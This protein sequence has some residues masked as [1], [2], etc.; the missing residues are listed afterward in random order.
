MT[1]LGRRIFV[2]CC[3]GLGALLRGAELPKGR[4]LEKVACAADATQTYALYIPT[5]ADPAHRWPVV[6]CF[7]PGARGHV[8]VERF[9]DAAEK[10]GYVIAGSNNSRNG[11]WEANA[12]AINAMVND[13]NRFLPIDAQ[14][15]YLA[16]LSGGARVACQVALGGM[17]K[18]VVACS[19]AFVGSETPERLKFAFFG[20]AG[21]TDFNYLE[22]RRTDR[23]LEERRL[24]HRVVFHSG[25]HEWLSSELAVEALAWFELQA[26]RSGAKPKDPA[27]IE[28]QFAARRAAVPEQPLA[29]RVRALRGLVADFKGL[30]AVGDVEKEAAT[31]GATREARDALKAERAAER[32]EE[33]L[34]D[35]LAVAI[36]EGAAREVTKTGVDLRA[37]SAAKDTPDGQMAARVLQGA[38]TSCSETA[39]E[40]MRTE[41]YADAVPLLEMMTLLRPERPQA[42]FD[43]ARCQAYRGDKKRAVAAL[44]QAVAAG[45]KD[46]ARIEG[47]KVFAT[48]RTEPA[49]LDLVG[50]MR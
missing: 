8:P 49:F 13:V 30:T 23:E 42:F 24:T 50:A 45:F 6:F 33:A 9:K 37:R 18:G 47:E 48:L 39:R 40:L 26:V 41:S 12:N 17:A 5:T 43:L 27:W 2:L 15:V 46:A 44:Q 36:R 4:L 31:L 32:R 19:A 38:Y 29:E 28:A 14:R 20:T 11:P 35:E 25:G 22:L 16:G 7:D 10:F 21:A 1:P 3:V 34:G